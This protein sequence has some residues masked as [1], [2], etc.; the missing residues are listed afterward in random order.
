M[1]RDDGFVGAILTDPS[2]EAVQLV[3]ADWLDERGDP[4]GEFLRLR[5][6][7]NRGWAGSRQPPAELASRMEELR[8]AI[9]PVWVALLDTLG[10]PS[11]PAKLWFECFGPIDPP[12]TEPLVTRRVWGRQGRLAGLATL[13]SQFRLAGPPDAGLAA[14]LRLLAELIHMD[15]GV[16]YYGPNDFTIY[17]FLAELPPGGGDPGPAD[18]LAGLKARD[19]RGAGS[20]ELDE[21]YVTDDRREQ[22]F[23]RH[24][25]GGVL[26]GPHA[27]LS[28]YVAPGRL[29][30]VLLH[31]R[32]QEYAKHAIHFA[33]GPSPRGRRMVGVVAGGYW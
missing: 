15:L 17:P 23:F 7:W 6:E 13:A 30:Y 21:D 10:V 32:H 16:C 31:T 3:Y 18:I 2:D 27:L 28:R 9:D 19:F 20:G 24:E 11:E 14:D 26:Q 12:L 1:E 25:E 22:N 33:V 4:R 5:A 29:W 8:A